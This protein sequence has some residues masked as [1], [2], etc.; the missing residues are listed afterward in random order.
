[1]HTKAKKYLLGGAVLGLFLVLV[2]GGFSLWV[3]SGSTTQAKLTI[4]SAAGLPIGKVGSTY[5][6]SK[7]LSAYQAL[8]PV[9]ERMGTSYTDML[10]LPEVAAS[11][12]ALSTAD[13][14]QAEQALEKDLDYTQAVAAVGKSLAANTLVK[15]YVLDA[16]LK[17]WYASHAA[18]LEPSLASRATLVK[19]KLDSGV[20]I[21]EV[22]KQYSEDLAT[23]WFSG[24]TGYIDIANAVPEYREQVLKLQ[25]GQR[26]FV[27]TRFGIHVLEILDIA[28]QNG[29]SY[30]RIAEVVLQPKDYT[31]WLSEQLQTVPIVWYRQP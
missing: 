20:A 28:K 10:R 5:I 3:Y 1:M 13:L 15:Q 29:Q 22:A 17:T 11:K 18:E 30:Y 9:I 6:S 8:A 26:T 21:G 7:E 23:K 27:Y 31:A 19:T 24:D 16:K 12:V 4:L 14:E 2:A 25:K